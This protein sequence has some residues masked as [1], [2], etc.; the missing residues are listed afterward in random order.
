MSL[1]QGSNIIAGGISID[2]TPT[3]GSSNAV[4]SGG[5]YTALSSKAS[6]DLDNIT[7]AGKAESV[8]WGRQFTNVGTVVAIGG[9]NIAGTYSLGFT[10]N[11]VKIGVFECCLLTTQSGFSNIAITTD[12]ITTPTNVCG[13]NNFFRA[14]GTITVPFINSITISFPS[15]SAGIGNGSTVKFIGYM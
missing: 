7:S 4:S 11:K 10:D 9:S 1:R 15:S 8:S 13:T 12:V 2:S 5:V 14:D 3:S 6:I